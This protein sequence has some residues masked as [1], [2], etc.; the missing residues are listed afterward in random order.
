MFTKAIVRE[1]GANFGDGITTS[2]LGTPDYEK[3]LRQHAAYCDALTGCG[4]E[5]IKLEPDPNFPD[6]P[7]VEDTAVVTGEVAVIARPGDPRRRGEEAEIA[8]LLAGYWPIEQI[9]SPG[10][11]DGGDVLEADGRFFVGLGG[12]TDE[13]GARQLQAILEPHGLSV[14]IVKAG[15]MLH[16]KSGV[17]Y[18]GGSLAVTGELAGA[19]AFEDYE[20]VIIPEEESYAANCLFV[21]G[22]LLIAAG[23]PQTKRLLTGLGHEIIE[24]DMSEFMKMD[25]GLT[26]LSIRF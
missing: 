13:S 15:S 14:S 18:A 1:P 17:N 7:F 26:C 23:F 24:L 3:A 21:N 2:S 9:K 4:L 5:L 16:L 25:G 11:L 19:D 12:R 20:R 22:R 6:C 8:G 10:T